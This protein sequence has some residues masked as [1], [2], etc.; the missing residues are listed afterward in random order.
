V[1]ETRGMPRTNAAA[2]EAVILAE[3]GEGPFHHPS[4]RQHQKTRYGEVRR[5][6]K[7]RSSQNSYSTH[8]GE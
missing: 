2:R 6:P 1:S 8:F 4:P 5:M 3:P 7:R